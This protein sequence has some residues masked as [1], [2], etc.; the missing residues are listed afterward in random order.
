MSKCFFIWLYILSTVQEDVVEVDEFPVD[1]DVS[2]LLQ[3][4][5]NYSW[6]VLVTDNDI[7]CKDQLV[8]DFSLLSAVLYAQHNFGLKIIIIFLV[9][10]LSSDMPGCGSGTGGDLPY[11]SLK[12][13]FIQMFTQASLYLSYGSAPLSPGLDAL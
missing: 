10:P 2:W 13:C 8:R 7:Q 5:C 6:N 12:G 1:P 3:F 11:K 9:A 4:V